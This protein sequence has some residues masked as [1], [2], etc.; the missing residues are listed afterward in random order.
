MSQHHATLSPSKLPALELCGS[1]EGKGGSA[2]AQAGTDKHT[3]IAQI[4]EAEKIQQ[5]WGFD[6]KFYELDEE[7]QKQIQWGL[8]YLD[9]VLKEAGYSQSGLEIEK[10]VLVFPKEGGFQEKTFGSLDVAFS[11]HLIDWKFGNVH[12][13]QLQMMTYAL[14]RMQSHNFDKIVVHEVYPKLKKFKRYIVTRE[15]AET[16]V[17]GVIA[18]VESGDKTKGKNGWCSFCKHS[19]YCEAFTGDLG[20]RIE[21]NPVEITK[22]DFAK[23]VELVR[24]DRQLSAEET[25]FVAKCGPAWVQAL[26]MA[27]M[28]TYWAEEVKELAK[29]AVFACGTIPG[30]KINSKAGRS[31]CED[32]G[33]V[34]TRS[35]F[36]PEEFLN[37]VTLSKTKLVEAMAE[38]GPEY[39]GQ[40][41]AGFLG[42]TPEYFK[43]GRGGKFT[44]VVMKQATEEIFDG[45]FI[46]GEKSYSVDVAPD[47]LLRLEAEARV[48]IE[49]ETKHIEVP[50]MEQLLAGQ[51]Y[52]GIEEVQPL[53]KELK[54]EDGNTLGI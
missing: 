5:P 15:E 52:K 49:Q 28:A 7:G 11:N 13:Y 47:G 38:K 45:L 16:R 10:K 43:P 2:H 6:F 9:S 19:T 22:E 36:T 41:L 21:M 53:V 3:A 34:F 50:T 29:R 37:L 30:L 40:I 23:A 18:K 1:Y 17:F 24:D 27:K 8:E 42:E 25:D 46:P 44:K 35:G 39:I 20:E 31:T 4:L 54:D 14:A 32:A 12:E 51:E 26:E 33:S 48:Q